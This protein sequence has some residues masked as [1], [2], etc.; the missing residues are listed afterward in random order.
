MCSLAVIKGA[1][2]KDHVL[3]KSKKQRDGSYARQPQVRVRFQLLENLGTPPHLRL[4]AC[5]SM[6]QHSKFF[7]GTVGA[8]SGTH[9]HCVWG[10]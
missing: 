2:L 4:E 8:W 3:G 5:R 6:L 1:I 9:L 7:L 10:G